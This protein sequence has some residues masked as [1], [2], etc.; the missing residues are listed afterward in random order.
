MIITILASVFFTIYWSENFFPEILR[1]NFKPFTC[2]PCLSVWVAIGLFF[3]PEI[4]SQITL[5]AF[6]SGILVS[7]VQRLKRKI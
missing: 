1:L 2:E 5:V 7:V 3:M 4:Y 6:G